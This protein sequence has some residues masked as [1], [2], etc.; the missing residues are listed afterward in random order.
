M[1]VGVS[2]PD[3]TFPGID[4]I[5]PDLSALS[6]ERIDAVFLTHGH[7]DHIGA[8]PLLREMVRRAG[9]RLPVHARAWRGAGWR[10]R[11]S[12]RRPRSRRGGREPIRAGAFARHVLPR[13]PLGAR[14]GGD[15]DRGRGRCGSSTPA[16]SSSTTIRPTARR[17]TARGSRRPPARASTSRSSTRPTPSG[18]AARSRSGVA[19]RGAPRARL[20]R[21]AAAGSSSRRSRATS[22]ASRRRV[23]AALV[24][25]PP[26]GAARPQHARRWPR[27]PSGCGRLRLPS[28]SLVPAASE[29]RGGPARAASLPDLGKPGRALLGALPAGARTSTRT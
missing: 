5:A 17:P 27:S 9:L 29:L 2:F 6:G 15:P 19:G 14:F 12:P 4:R 13:L 21:G 20:R 10:R 18:R 25:G 16:T 8:L 7:E 26:R 3:E 22:R 11:R 24:R 23:E 28:G 1:D